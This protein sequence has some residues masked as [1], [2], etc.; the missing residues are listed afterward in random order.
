M[1][2]TSSDSGKSSPRNSHQANPRRI[3]STVQ[4]DGKRFSEAISNGN[5]SQFRSTPLFR[6]VRRSFGSSCRW[7]AASKRPWSGEE[8]P[9]YRLPDLGA[10]PS[11]SSLS[12]GLTGAEAFA[13]ASGKQLTAR[14]DPHFVC[15]VSSSVIVHHFSTHPVHPHLLSSFPAFLLPSAPSPPCFPSRRLPP[16]PLQFR[17]L[18]RWPQQPVRKQR[19]GPDLLPRSS[20]SPPSARFRGCSIP[21]CSRGAALL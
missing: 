2:P 8:D 14:Q 16:W 11:Q 15:S 17:M 21:W 3:R 4:S 5:Q 1:K 20:L 18:K 6:R 19:P 9:I 7:R 12:W 10:T 13:E